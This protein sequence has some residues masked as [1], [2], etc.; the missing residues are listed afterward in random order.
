MDESPIT[1][2]QVKDFL[3]RRWLII[4]LAFVGT[5][6]GTYGGLNLLTEKYETEAK[7]LVRLGRENV[8]PPAT[9]R[10]NV[11]VTGL[12]LQDAVNE[13]QIL[14]SAELVSE[15]VDRIGVEA[16]RDKPTLPTTLIGW[17]KYYAKT[18]AKTVKRGYEEMLY[19]ADLKKR[20]GEREAAIELI[21]GET[22]AEPERDSD[23]IAIRLRLPNYALAERIEQEMV[24]LYMERRGSIRKDEGVREFYSDEV[25]EAK[26]QLMA[27]EGA[28]AFLKRT[29]AITSPQEQRSLLLRQQRELASSL[30]TAKAEV[31]A[32]ERQCEELKKQLSDTPEQIRSS[33]QEIP[34]PQALSLRERLAAARAQASVLSNKYQ[35]ESPVIQN[36]RREI[37]DIETQLRAEAAIST[38]AVTYQLNPIRQALT[39]RLQEAEVSIAGI[40]SRSRQ[41]QEAL[42]SV[43]RELRVL[44]DAD[45]N[46]ADIERNRQINEDNYLALVKRSQAA[47][48][49]SQ[50]H[51]S[52]ISNV[53]VLQQPATSPVPVYPKKMLIFYISLGVGLLL[54]FVIA[55]LADYFDDHVRDPDRTEAMSNLRCLGVAEIDPGAPALGA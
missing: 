24:A 5:I 30:S 7:I 21:R 39:Q 40:Q 42:A 6:L 18:A 12:R 36:V 48:I 33:R 45:N 20:L 14:T 1:L 13:I 55:L 44:D 47:E 17:A 25:K 37:A 54:G 32:L 28:R 11:L 35:P 10:G 41:Q 38:G 43:A 31:A 2:N 23:V 19:A 50:L 22:V 51:D 53:S 29:K 27:S 34:N 49:D 9:A 26:Q 4:V 52:R 15:V 46:L 16:F 8:D 3:R